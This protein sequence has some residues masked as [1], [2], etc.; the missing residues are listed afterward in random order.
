[1][2]LQRRSA[3]RRGGEAGS[4][5]RAPIPPDGT[6]RVPSGRGRGPGRA[7]GTPGVGAAARTAAGAVCLGGE[8][9]PGLSA[10]SRGR[11]RAMVPGTGRAC[12]GHLVLRTGGD[13]GLSAC[14]AEMRSSP[15]ALISPCAAGGR[16][17]G[18]YVFVTILK[19]EGNKR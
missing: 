10:E 16:G 5:V 6:V 1:M 15:K 8:A 14:G 11:R 12:P 9:S 7:P 17:H 18:K 2:C 3:G 4:R 13:H 19:P